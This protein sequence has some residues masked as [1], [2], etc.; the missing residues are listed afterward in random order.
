MNNAIVIKQSIVIHTLKRKKFFDRN[1]FVDIV[2]WGNRKKIKNK[3]IE[4]EK[5]KKT[6]ERKLLPLDKMVSSLFLLIEYFY[7]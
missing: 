5:K 1:S 2:R 6:K 7:E 3:E 4:K